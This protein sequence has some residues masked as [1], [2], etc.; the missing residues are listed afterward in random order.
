MFRRHAAERH[1][2]FLIHPL[3][4]AVGL[5][6][7]T[8]GQACGGPDEAAELLPEYRGELG[9]LIRDHIRWEAVKPKHVLQN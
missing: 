5:G 7:E 2:H 8:R 6:M 3:R 4:L 9:T 1:L